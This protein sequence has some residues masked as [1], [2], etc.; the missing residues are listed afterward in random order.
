MAK[1]IEEIEE[2]IR[3]AKQQ[4][5]E[6]YAKAKAEA[7]TREISVIAQDTNKALDTKLNTKL[8]S[9][10]DTDEGINTKITETASKLAE[11]GLKVQEKKVSASLNKAKKEDN[12]SE[13]ALLEDRY[14]AF[15]QDTA[16]NEKWKKNFINILYNIWFV[17]ITAICF[18]SLAPFYIFVKVIETQK[19]ILKFVAIVVG[20]LLLIACLGGLTFALLKKVG[21]I[22]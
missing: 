1:T 13:F 19:G 17:I 22:H 20:V 4:Q 7:E 21:V 3:L 8:V 6:A 2:E 18:F 9:I 11:S 15:G 14:R 10:I 16:P 12:D 5:D